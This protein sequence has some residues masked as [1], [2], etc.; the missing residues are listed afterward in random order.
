MLFLSHSSHDKTH[1]QKLACEL[2][3][4]G[5]TV[6]L[7]EWRIRVGQCIATAIERALT[8]CRFVILVLSPHAVSSGW[9]SREWKAKYWTEVEEDRIRVLPVLVSK[10]EVPLLLR[11]RRYVDLSVAYDEGVDRLI[12]SLREYIVLDSAR[13][14]YAY[15]P[16]VR[17]ELSGGSRIEARNKHWDRFHAYVRSLE[18]A[19]RLSVQQLNSL[20]YLGMW[21]LTVTQLRKE[22][23]MLGFATPDN[24]EF[25]PDLI[26]AIEDFQRTHCL[27][28]ID[29]VFGQLTYRQMYELHRQNESVAAPSTTLDPSDNTRP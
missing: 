15:A 12:Q 25:T 9:V 23:G 29:G 26:R 10:C 24:S 7:D 16:V 6:W 5:F 21:G 2:Q 22:L 28:H 20:Q 14:F 3:R 19:E 17:N 1:V 4:A 8:D 27:R 18:G 11:T 13:D